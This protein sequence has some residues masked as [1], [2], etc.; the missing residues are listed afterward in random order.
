MAD[1]IIDNYKL[2]TDNIKINIDDLVIKNKEY[3]KRI[4][5]IIKKV[6]KECN[7][8][9][10]CILEKYENPSDKLLEELLALGLGIYKNNDNNYE[11]VKF[12]AKTLMNYG[13]FIRS[14]CDENSHGECKKLQK[15][16]KPQFITGLGNC[17]FLNNNQFKTQFY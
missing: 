6:N 16:F 7:N 10:A 14:L 17:Y 1:Y 9:R 15:K 3:K 2:S 12:N 5:D 8:N 13:L 4:L 11:E